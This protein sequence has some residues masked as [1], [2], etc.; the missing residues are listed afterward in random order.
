MRGSAWWKGADQ[1]IN[2]LLKKYVTTVDAKV[3]ELV[4]GKARVA[5]PGE[6]EDPLV[7]TRPEY[8]V[9]GAAPAVGEQVLVLANFAGG[10]VI[11]DGMSEADEAKLDTLAPPER[12]YVAPAWTNYAR[13]FPTGWDTS[14]VPNPKVSVPALGTA[15]AGFKWLLDIVGAI[16][17]NP[18]G[19][20]VSY[21][22]SA[23]FDGIASTGV[24][25]GG[26]LVNTQGT[27][28][29]V[30]YAVAPPATDRDFTVDFTLWCSPGGTYDIYSGP[31]P[32]VRCYLVA[33]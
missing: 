6:S 13:T 8:P 3:I 33:I 16:R 27:L 30:K 14:V 32:A 20:T 17:V 2:A 28:G 10:W 26:T 5:F 23:S 15:P 19:T 29:L 4:G 31:F 9:I 18:Q 11:T 1:R 22:I 7:N 24:D 21:L 25:G 12:V